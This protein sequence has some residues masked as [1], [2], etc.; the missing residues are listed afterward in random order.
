MLAEVLNPIAQQ[1]AEAIQMKLAELP[2]LS[3]ALICQRP[4]RI[5]VEPGWIEIH[6]ALEQV[7]TRLRRAALDLNPG[8]LPWLGCVV[9]FVYD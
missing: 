7:D 5:Q 6:F 3:L 9:R 1:L 2:E 4:G 8:F